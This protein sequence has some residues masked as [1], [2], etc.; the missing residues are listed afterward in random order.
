MPVSDEE[1]QKEQ[2]FKAGDVE[3]RLQLYRDF[4]S[5]CLRCD[6]GANVAHWPSHAWCALQDPSSTGLRRY[7]L[8]SMTAHKFKDMDVPNKYVGHAVVAVMQGLAA[9]GNIAR[10]TP[11]STQALSKGA[12]G[13]RIILPDLRRHKRRVRH[14]WRACW[15]TGRWAPYGLP[16]K[17]LSWDSGITFHP[18]SDHRDCRFDFAQ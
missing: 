5:P 13:L 6:F 11:W 16:G 8:S 18:Q 1:Q 15:G 10:K 3:S 12:K 7:F 2:L 17:T 4:A 14:G 9:A